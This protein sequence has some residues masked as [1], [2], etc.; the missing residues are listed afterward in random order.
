MILTDDNFASIV[1]AIEEGRAVYDNIRR[2]V[3][4]IFTSNVPELVPF[5][6]FVMFHIPLPLTVMQILAIDLGTDMIPALALGTE[7]PEPG[8]MRRPPR[9]RSEQLLN[10]SVLW[11]VFL[12]L[13][14]LQAAAAMLAFYWMYWSHGWRPYMGVAGMVAMGAGTAGLVLYAK[15]T[16]MT[17]AAVVTTQIGNGFAQ[18]TNRESI[19]KVGFFSNRFLL[20]GILIELIAINILIYVQPFQRVFQHGPLAPIDWVVLI[21]LVPTLLI[22]DEIRKFLL[23]RRDRMRNVSVADETRHIL[24]EQAARAPETPLEEEA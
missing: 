8:I 20:W 2:F 10:W 23:R 24:E 9:S 22:A 12:F 13:G 3:T 4:Y 18:R 15:A 6:L 16:T 5:L 19:L 14:P 11:R 21:A 7:A 1:N 17:H